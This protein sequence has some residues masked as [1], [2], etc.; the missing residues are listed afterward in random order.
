MQL[1]QIN[2]I[3]APYINASKEPCVHWYLTGD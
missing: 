2:E 3:K 1:N